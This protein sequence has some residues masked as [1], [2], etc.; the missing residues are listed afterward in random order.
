[1]KLVPEIKAAWLAELRSGRYEQGT[2]LLRCTS[3]SKQ[4]HC[5]LGVLGELAVAAGLATWSLC[6]EEQVFMLHSVEEGNY[7]A[8]MP[9]GPVRDWALGE[10]NTLEGDLRVPLEAVQ[11]HFP[12]VSYNDGRESF[13]LDQLND[14]GVPFGVIADLIEECL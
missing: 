4:R 12:D 1:M 11:R 6:D 9:P 14:Q 2:G 7:S 5:C 3:D 8:Q 13:G 10:K